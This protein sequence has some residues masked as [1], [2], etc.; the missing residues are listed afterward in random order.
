[1]TRQ[2][3]RQIALFVEGDTE[4]ALPA[5]FHHWLDPKLEQ[6]VGI[7]PVKFKGVSNY[8]GDLAQKVESH[9]TK[10][11]A[12][13]VFGLLDLYGLPDRIDFSNASTVAEKVSTA[14]EQIRNLIPNHLGKRFFQHFAVHEVEAWLL[15]YPKKFPAD[16]QGQIGKIEKPETVDFNEPPAKF[17]NGILRGRYMK[18]V[19]AKKI[20]PY[21]DP[22]VAINKCPYLQKLATDLLAVAKRL[23]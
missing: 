9:L 21:V 22:Q 7:R 6:K 11:G 18:T 4:T 20:F 13:F 1:M 12:D 16:V 15:A 10:D 3:S 19:Y 2:R 5:F 17:L 14:R 23:Q 8:L